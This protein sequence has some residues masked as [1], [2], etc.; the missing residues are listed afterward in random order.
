MKLLR[1][2]QDSGILKPGGGGSMLL[3]LTSR[4]QGQELQC[5]RDGSI[6]FTTFLALE[7]NIMKGVLLIPIAPSGKGT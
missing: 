7:G 1:H 6:S 4:L 2:I 5:G 3:R